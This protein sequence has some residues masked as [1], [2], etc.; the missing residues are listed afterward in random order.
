VSDE[1]D[2]LR[3]QNNPL[4]EQEVLGLRAESRELAAWLNL[5]QALPGIVDVKKPVEEIL[6]H[7]AQAAA[8]A[9]GMQRVFFFARA[10]DTLQPIGASATRRLPPETMALLQAQASGLC[11]PPADPAQQ[12]LAQAVGLE[13][14]LWMSMEVKGLAPLLMIAGSDGAA[15]DDGMDDRTLVHFANLVQQ[16]GLLLKNR[17]L[18]AALEHE[19]HLLA[20]LNEALE[21]RVAE[22]SKEFAQANGEISRALT[23]MREKDRLMKEDLEQARSFQQSLL[24]A[25]PISAR[26]E[27]D[28]L[29]RPVDLV[30]GDLY[31]V[32]EFEPGLFRVFVADATGH[33]VQAS[34]RTIVLKSEYDQLKVM[35]AEPREVLQALNQRLLAR[36]RPG[37]MLCTACCVDIDARDGV[38]ICHASAAHPAPIRVRGDGFLRL[39]LDSPLLGAAANVEF[40]QSETQL[41]PD[42]WLILYTDGISEQIVHGCVFDF[43]NAIVSAA[44]HASTKITLLRQVLDQFISFL[45]PDPVEDDIVLISARVRP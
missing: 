3:A 24:P 38:K 18:V 45:G 35:Y 43:E 34:L 22:R 4:L 29:Y 28:A 9:T 19:K 27:F 13:R 1:T 12:G 31:D 14:F 41:A 25:L 26:M 6:L 11:N 32:F 21:Q 42:D 36:H 2:L 15:V 5:A 17:V 20:E 39:H 23:L 37:D 10:A 30:G 7:V 40:P 44:R 16:F 8:T 33:G